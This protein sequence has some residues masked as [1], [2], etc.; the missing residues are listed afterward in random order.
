MGRATFRG[1]HNRRKALC[2]IGL[3]IFRKSGLTFANLLFLAPGS[4]AS[5]KIL[6]WR[7]QKWHYIYKKQVP[8]SNP[9]EY[10]YHLR[11]AGLDWVNNN[12][13]VMRF[14][15]WFAEMRP[16]ARTFYQDEF[17][18]WCALQARIRDRQTPPAPHI[19]KIKAPGG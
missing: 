6:L 13:A 11:S 18:R 1:S 9:V 3:Y 4:G 5:L 8:W 7:W 10:R 15:S 14:D 16:E 12:F 2:F 19:I 17:K